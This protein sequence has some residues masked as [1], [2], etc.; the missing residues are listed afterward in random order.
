TIEEMEPTQTS[1]IEPLPTSTKYTYESFQVVL[2]NYVKQLN[3]IDLTEKDLRNAIKSQL[4]RDAVLEVITA[5]LKPEEDQVWARHILVEDE[6]SAQ[7][8]LE[9][10]S[11]GED[12]TDLAAELSQDSS[13]M[14][15]GD[16][17][18]FGKGRMVSE[19]EDAAYSLEIGE[20][21]DPIE[22]EFGWHIIQVL[23]HEVRFLES[24]EFNTL[25]QSYFAEWLE[26]LKTEENI[27]IFDSWLDE[28]PGIPT[29]PPDLM[30]EF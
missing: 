25:R 3:E 9:R 26:N 8:V 16:L 27:Q 20:I 24:M 30:I 28:I 23:G 21:S 19:F 10:I 2:E 7:S 4:L 15:G 5:D 1:T 13:S 12:W 11:A 6:A 18:W 29:I 22:T 14:Q 17:G